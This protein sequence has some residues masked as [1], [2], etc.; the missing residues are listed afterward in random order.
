MKLR[1]RA[2]YGQIQG[3]VKAVIEIKRNVR[4]LEVADRLRKLI[5]SRDL[6]F[7]DSIMPCREIA[8]S[9]EVSL[10]TA[11][12][13]VSHLVK[14]GVLYQVRGSGTFVGKKAGTAR[15]LSIGCAVPAFD[16]D[17]TSTQVL[18]QFGQLAVKTLTGH[19]CEVRHIPNVVF[20]NYDELQTYIGDL[21]GLLISGT[22]VALDQCQSLSR[23]QIPVV[24]FQ[25]EYEH[26]LSF[27]QV[28]PDHFVAMRQAF[29]L[30]KK[31]SCPSI[32]AVYQDLANLRARSE[33]FAA[34]ALEAGFKEEQLHRRVTTIGEAYSLGLEL[35]TC[36]QGTLVFSA[37]DNLTIPIYKA[38]RDSGLTPGQDFSLIGYDNFEAL[39]AGPEETPV[40]TAIDYSREAVVRKAVDLLVEE[41]RE[42]RSYK[43]IIKMPTRLTIRQ[44][45]LTPAKQAEHGR[46]P[47]N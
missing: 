27:S 21:D 34:C 6:S 43:Q 25:S 42:P 12:N 37:S 17:E 14:E 15:K 35:A 19:N 24:I 38:F 5:Q 29:A 44:S 9:Y 46:N 30:L 11:R 20:H 18:R 3:Q 10:K 32:V 39:G 26:N 45:A 13:A 41:I 33:A 16:S 22:Q 8:Q 40:L 1:L 31:E 28:V 47:Q 7:G 4:Y 36:A 23:L 2:N